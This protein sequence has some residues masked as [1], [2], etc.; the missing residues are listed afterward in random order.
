[1]IEINQAHRH[2]QKLDLHYKA[3][4]TLASEAGVPKG[5]CKK[6]VLSSKLALKVH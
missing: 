4:A 6:H 1:M 5:Q 3:K 2:S